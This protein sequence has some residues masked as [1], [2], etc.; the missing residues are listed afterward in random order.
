MASGARR[1]LFAG[2]AVAAATLVAAQTYLSMLHHGHDWWRLF[3]WQLASWSYWGALGPML[4]RRGADLVAA[5]T[6]DSADAVR[7][8]ADSARTRATT[9]NVALGL[10]VLCA[11]LV[12]AH[13]LFSALVLVGLQ[14]F[15]PVSHMDLA[16]A[17]LYLGL[18]WTLVDVLLFWL[19]VAIGRV[20]ANRR[21]T[22][23][24]ELR[25]A[26]L[27]TELARAQLE[28]LRLKVQP[29]F[30]FNTLNSIAAL[31][32]RRDNDEALEMIIELSH[33]LR[34]SLDR[35]DSQL[36]PLHRELD[37]VE[38]YVELQRRRFADRLSFVRNVSQ[39]LDDV[40]VP[41]LVLQPLVENAIRHGLEP[42][43]RPVTIT[44]TVVEQ[45]S[46]QPH[47]AED[48]IIIRVEDDGAG[49]PPDFDLEESEGFG[50]GGIRERLQHLYGDAG[51]ALSIAARVAGADGMPGGGT[52]VELRVPRSDV[53][54]ASEPTETGE[55]HDS[56]SSR[57][58]A[59]G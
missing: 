47:S 18:P 8:P 10:V 42:L 14:P 58:K 27:A 9:R 24:L 41:S 53:T 1:L 35:S 22:R 7:A 59:A 55:R 28:T 39:K 29:H 23:Q 20:A 51:A 6:R 34:L 43:S 44:L 56:R 3:L 16:G 38:R 11:I 31:V 52:I 57:L 45:S 40:E 33:L 25:E 17:V 13:I 4:I 49:L 50:L 48:S 15:Q 12:T 46:P 5:R 2:A 54:V 21:H 32:R 26:H 36:V 30:L 37:F 19:L